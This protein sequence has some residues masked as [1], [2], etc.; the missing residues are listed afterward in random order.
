[1]RIELKREGG[2]AFFPGLTKPRSVDLETLPPDTAEAIRRGV[3]EA[4]FF[5]QP[6]AVGTASRGADRTR[7]T[8]TIEDGGRKHTV[9]FLE[10]VEEP[11]LRALVE[12]LQKVEKEQRAAA[13]AQ[14]P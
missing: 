10:P 4:R 12:L 8:V 2:L 14:H 1:M 9:Q 5:E 3:Q 11:N 13:R 7:Y 6:A